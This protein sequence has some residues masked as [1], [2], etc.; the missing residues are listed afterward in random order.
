MEDREAMERAMALAKRARPHPNPR[1]G[2][3]LLDAADQ[4]VAEG[5]HR[6]AGEPHAER[7]ALSHLADRGVAT[8]AVVTL[9]PC[10]HTGRTPPCVEAIIEAG[11]TRVVVGSVD[12]DPRVRGAGIKSLEAAGIEV[13][14]IGPG[15]EELDPGYARHRRDGRPRILLKLAATLDG[16]TAAA[17]GE[18]QWITGESARKQAHELRSEVDAVVVGIG[19]VI[20]DDPQLTVRLDGYEGRQPRS[21]VIAGQRSLP[22][23]HSLIDP[24]VYGPDAGGGAIPMPGE[25][26]VD[27]GGVV[28]DLGD[29]GYLDVMVEGGARLAASFW[30]AGLVDEVLLF[31]AGKIAGGVG[32]PMFDRVFETLTDAREIDIVSVSHA[33]HDIVIRGIVRPSVPSSRSGQVA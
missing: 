21:V 30:S 13:S 27:L 25:S 22:A 23:T 26:G 14:V 32:R 10:S 8:T 5:Y 9:E 11:I 18:S 31:L 20:A 12:P 6:A 17:N 19:T 3:V 16:Q 28:A 1:V 33:G 15:I 2:C 24:L 7:D 4:I 29:R